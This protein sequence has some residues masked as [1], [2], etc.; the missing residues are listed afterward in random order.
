MTSEYSWIG[1]RVLV[2]G[3]SGFVGRNLIPRLRE[4][5]CELITPARK[6]FDLLEQCRVRRLMSDTKPDV[7]FHLAALS[8]GILANQRFPGDFCYQNLLMS[9]LLLHEA[10][11]AGVK[12]YVTLIGGCSYPSNAPNPIAESEALEWIP[13]AGERSLLAGKANERDIGGS[14][15]APA[16]IRRHCACP[17]QSLWPIR[18]L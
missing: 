4:T 8:G 5:G 11:Q 10:W 2:T 7:V 6:D 14:I 9:T 17:W 12:K 1:K 16:W 15:S 3:A 18:Q 13:A